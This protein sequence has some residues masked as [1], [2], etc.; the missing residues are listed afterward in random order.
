MRDIVKAMIKETLRRGGISMSENYTRITDSKKV[1]EI[2][3]MLL[4]MEFENLIGQSEKMA[5]KAFKEI[6]LYCIQAI[7]Y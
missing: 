1:H 3:E 6:A 4:S 5:S 2:T 7:A